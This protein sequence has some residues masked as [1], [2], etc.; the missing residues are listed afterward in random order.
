MRNV[1][2]PEP[3]VLLVILI[4]LMIS[5]QRDAGPRSGVRS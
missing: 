3:L 4:L 5:P 1:A 2:A